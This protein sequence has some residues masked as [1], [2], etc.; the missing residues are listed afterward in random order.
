MLTGPTSSHSTS[1]DSGL[2]E[3]DPDAADQQ[4]SREQQLQALRR[5]LGD[6]LAFT[7]FQKIEMRLEVRAAG[8]GNPLIAAAVMIVL[9]QEVVVVVVVVVV[10]LFVVVLVAR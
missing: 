9:G 6:G 7:E 5:V 2:D 3:L 10:V 1:T 8:Q 4:L